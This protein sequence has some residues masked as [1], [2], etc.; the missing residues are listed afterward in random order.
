MIRIL[1]VSTLLTMLVLATLGLVMLGHVAYEYAVLS[2]KVD[3]LR[4]ELM[5]IPV[6][7][8]HPTNTLFFV[9]VPIA[10]LYPD[11]SQQEIRHE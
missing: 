6:K 2:A 7:D 8:A 10:S 1:A 9:D 5:G 4:I 11:W 3:L